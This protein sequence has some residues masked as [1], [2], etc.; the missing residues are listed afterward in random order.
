MK[1]TSLQNC[2]LATAKLRKEEISA[3]DEICCC[4]CESARATVR[5]YAH[6]FV[7]FCL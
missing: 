5:A 4:L 3:R 6:A 1:Q 7:L 2:I